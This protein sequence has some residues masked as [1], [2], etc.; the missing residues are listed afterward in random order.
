[1]LNI[2]F[3]PDDYIA[4]NDSRKTNLICF[5]LFIALMV[6]VGAAFAGIRLQ[7]RVLASK[8][9]MVNEKMEQTKVSI[10]QFEQIQA[11]FKMM[12]KTAL[13]AVDLL[14][15]VPR[16][17]LL[18]SITNNLPRGVSLLKLSLVQKE[19]TKTAA[20]SN[21]AA[22]KAQKT[23]AKT[24]T[25]KEK[26][27]ETYIGIEGVAP[28]DLQVAAFIR[29]LIYS[30]LLDRVALV[31]SKEYKVQDKTSRQFKLTA[32]LKKGASLTIDDIKHIKAISEQGGIRF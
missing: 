2:N 29:N 18:A 31:E 3:V 30:D 20:T 15:P 16:S 6:C 13:T 7:Q 26:S 23:A 5:I 21:Y 28:S 17:I 11:K 14:E 9:K 4:N 25:S 22:Q 24:P 8:E 27:M 32:M 1:M 10:K 19:P 12:S